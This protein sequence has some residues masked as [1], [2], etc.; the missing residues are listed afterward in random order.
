MSSVSP[1]NRFR[2]CCLNAN[3]LR[4]H[5]D[6]L[7]LHLH[8][9]Q[10]YDVLAITETWLS[11]LIPDSTVSLGGLH[12]IRSDRNVHGGGVALYI[13]DTYSAT[14]I[15][16]SNTEGH[17]GMNEHLMCEVTRSGS[18]PIFVAAVYRPPHVA[19]TTPVDF[20][21]QLSIA[22]DEYAHKV[23]MGDLNADQLGSSHDATYVCS[24][25]ND[26]SLKLVN[27]V[28]KLGQ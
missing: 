8:S 13:R 17:P 9:N 28:V 14:I 11:P 6:V 22:M 25:M 18:S 27:H 10:D 20:G 7:K 16:C 24:L 23:V 4:S 12:L 26:L 19:F 3:S 1:R 15:S 5:L 2:C 21:H